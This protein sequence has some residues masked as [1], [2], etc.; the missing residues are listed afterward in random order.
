LVDFKLSG[1]NAALIYEQNVILKAYQAGS[2]LSIIISVFI[3]LQ[4]FIGS[5]VHKMIGLE[6]L[7]ILQLLFFA[8]VIVDQ[9]FTYFLQSMNFLKYAA[10]GG[11]SNYSLIYNTDSPEAINLSYMTVDKKFLSAGLMKFFTLNVNLT[12]TFPALGL[13]YFTFVFTKK[14]Y[15][16]NRYL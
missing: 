3:L 9:K 13:I 6:T 15:K 2:I 5:Y 4:F 7:Q 16:R 1:I 14:Y 11:Y 10:Y 12:L 8:R